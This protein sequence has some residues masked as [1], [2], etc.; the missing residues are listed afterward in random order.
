MDEPES[1]NNTRTIGARWKGDIAVVDLSGPIDAV[2]IRDLE[3]P[4][5]ALLDKGARH[6]AIGLREVTNMDSSG[7]GFL[8][9]QLKRARAAG[10]TVHLYSLPAAVTPLFRVTGMA[11]VID[12]YPDEDSAVAGF[13]DQG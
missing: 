3:P 2:S 9:A 8:L 1:Q 11:R 4:F 10:G 13:A 7:L 12:I 5:Q 6:L